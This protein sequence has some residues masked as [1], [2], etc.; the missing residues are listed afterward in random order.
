MHGS[1]EARKETRTYQRCNDAG[2]RALGRAFKSKSI[3]GSAEA[4]KTTRKYQ[5]CRSKE[6][7]AGPRAPVCAKKVLR[8]THRGSA[9]TVA[10]AKGIWGGAS[11]VAEATNTTTTQHRR[12]QRLYQEENV[13]AGGSPSDSQEEPRETE[14]AKLRS[15]HLQPKIGGPR[16]AAKVERRPHLLPETGETKAETVKRPQQEVSV[17]E[18]NPKQTTSTQQAEGAE[19]RPEAER[20]LQQRKR[21][22]ETRGAATSKLGAAPGRRKP[23]TSGR[24]KPRRKP[25]APG[26]RKPSQAPTDPRARGSG[27]FPQ[28]DKKSTWPTQRAPT[29][30][31]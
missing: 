24:R 13:A 20:R 4:Q 30:K 14:I 25:R 27:P 15:L 2:P 11:T 6:K 8:D 21:I 17:T 26:R 12:H 5:R 10:E 18:R 31:A 3:N 1:V 9:S 23:R 22:R 7:N 28:R 19:T 16:T 29:A